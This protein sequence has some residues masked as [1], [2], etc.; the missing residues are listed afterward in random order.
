MKLAHSDV[1]ARVDSVWFNLCDNALIF[2][3][4]G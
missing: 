3:Y 1:L 4:K 2:R